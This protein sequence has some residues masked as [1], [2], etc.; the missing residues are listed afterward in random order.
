MSVSSVSLLDGLTAT[1]AHDYTIKYT[2]KY[3]VI[4]TSA[5]DGPLVVMNGSGLPQIWDYYDV[6]GGVDVN[7][8]ARTMTATQ[9]SEKRTVWEVTINWEPLTGGQTVDDSASDPFN[10]PT[11]YW[12]EP[13]N[14]THTVDTDNTGKPIKNTANKPYDEPQ[15]MEATRMVLVAEKPYATLQE[16][17]D[18]NIAHAM[19]VNDAAFKG[20]SARQALC[21]SILSSQLMKENDVEF[22]LAT[23][24]IEFNED[25]W[26]VEIVNRGYTYI[27]GAG[28][29]AVVVINGERPS[30]P[31]LL[32]AD[33]SITPQGSVGTT[34]TFEVIR[35]SDF[36]LLGI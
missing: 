27:D 17:I 6:S 36:T 20:A 14:Y 5:T 3:R 18:L 29:E 24:R 16:I 7:A 26:D 13:V 15:V 19:S 10:R 28:E 34:S 32:E 35:E 31:V 2:A 1:A 21:R 4:T 23:F 9:S 25:T 12:I 30:E 22:Y 33:G 8:F 11:R